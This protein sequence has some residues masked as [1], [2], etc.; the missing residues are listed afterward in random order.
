GDESLAVQLA[1][2]KVVGVT[3]GHQVTAIERLG[4]WWQGQSHGRTPVGQADILV[5]GHFHNMRISTSGDDR[6]IFSAPTADAGSQWFR[7]ISGHDSAP[8]VMSFT[9]DADGW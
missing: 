3:H 4:T 1:G 6:W 2:G 7:N 5:A 8:G 9:V